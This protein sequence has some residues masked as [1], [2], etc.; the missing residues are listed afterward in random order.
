MAGAGGQVVMVELANVG[1]TFRNE[2]YGQWVLRGNVVDDNPAPACD[3]GSL[4][5]F[6]DEV[7]SDPGVRSG[8]IANDLYGVA[9]SSAVRNVVFKIAWLFE[10]NGEE[11]IGLSA[12]IV[13]VCNV[14]LASTFVFFKA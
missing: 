2:C 1:D 13:V 14:P 12:D 8:Y 9:D 11:N 4:K 7:Y 3:I 10:R 5:V 6:V